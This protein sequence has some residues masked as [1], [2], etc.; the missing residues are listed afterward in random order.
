MVLGVYGRAS[1]IACGDRTGLDIAEVPRLAGLGVA[2]EAEAIRSF[3]GA[4]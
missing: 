3:K 4:T 2:A 1:A